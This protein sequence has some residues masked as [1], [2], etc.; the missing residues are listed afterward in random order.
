MGQCLTTFKTRGMR[1]RVQCQLREGHKNR[2]HQCDFGN[3]VA[4]V[5]K[6]APGKG[7]RFR[8]TAKHRHVLPAYLDPP[9]TTPRS[10]KRVGK[11]P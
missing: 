7:L 11:K 4:R 2:Y 1:R 5:W 8:Y 6:L 9:W 3:W 10:T